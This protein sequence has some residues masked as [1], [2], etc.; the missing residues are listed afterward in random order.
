MM[1][2]KHLSYS[3]RQQLSKLLARVG[4]V[5]VLRSIGQRIATEHPSADQGDKYRTRVNEIAS[6]LDS[7]RVVLGNE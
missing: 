2:Y 3:D 7:D 1:N 4:T 5:E 6:D